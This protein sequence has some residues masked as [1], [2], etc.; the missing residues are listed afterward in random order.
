MNVE[1]VINEW[2]DEDIKSKLKSIL[3]VILC[4]TNKSVYWTMDTKSGEVLIIN[5][6]R[7]LINRQ[8]EFI[9]R[10]FLI[11]IFIQFLNALFGAGAVNYTYRIFTEAGVATPSTDVLYLG[12]TIILVIECIFTC[13]LHINYFKSGLIGVNNSKREK[14]LAYPILIT[15]IFVFILY[16]MHIWGTPERLLITLLILYMLGIVV[17]CR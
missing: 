9:L 11:G 13:H 15:N 17:Y 5:K 16:G 6:D 1:K 14:I 3:R 4:G 7:H 10:A 12:E 2:L 8:V